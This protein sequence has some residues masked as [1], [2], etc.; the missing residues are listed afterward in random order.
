MCTVKACDLPGGRVAKRF[1]IGHFAGPASG[2]RA[3]CK[4]F[5]T[6]RLCNPMAALLAHDVV[7]IRINGVQAP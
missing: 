6:A 2:I 4:A 5:G 7:W 1:V 3:N